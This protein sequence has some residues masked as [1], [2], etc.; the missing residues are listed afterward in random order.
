L[1]RR[2]KEGLRARVRAKDKGR[3]K[4]GERRIGLRIRWWSSEKVES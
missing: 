2:G 4:R 1:R 3:V